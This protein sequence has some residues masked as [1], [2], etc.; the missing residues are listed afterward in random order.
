MVLKAPPLTRS[1]A[2][3]V[4]TEVVADVSPVIEVLI[5]QK[6]DW[7]VYKIYNKL[8]EKGIDFEIIPN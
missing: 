8:G 7:D 4:D 5:S 2:V 6:G 3:I 1:V